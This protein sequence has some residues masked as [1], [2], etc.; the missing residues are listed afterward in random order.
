MVLSGTL[1]ADN[2]AIIL[3]SEKQGPMAGTVKSLGADKWQF[4]LDGAPATDPGLGFSRVS[5]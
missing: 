1:T 2:A 3:Q 5:A 4:N